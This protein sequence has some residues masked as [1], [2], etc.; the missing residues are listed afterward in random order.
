MKLCFLF[1]S[2][3]SFLYSFLSFIMYSLFV[4]FTLLACVFLF[5]FFFV[6]CNYVAMT[7]FHCSRKFDW[8][9]RTRILLLYMRLN[10][11]R[12]VGNVTKITWVEV[13]TL[14][15]QNYLLKYSN[16]NKN[17]KEP[18]KEINDEHKIWKHKMKKMKMKK[19]KKNKMRNRNSNI[20]GMRW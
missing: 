13:E 19:K 5:S 9:T 11:R 20:I 6:F 14:Q 2:T 17:K 18:T 10:A 3:F 12:N 1:L 16:N 15:Q 8:L 4:L 7:A